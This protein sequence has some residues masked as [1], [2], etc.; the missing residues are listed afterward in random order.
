MNKDSLL[1]K[2]SDYYNIKPEKFEELGILDSLVY[3]DTP[4]FLNPKLL[5]GCEIS[6]FKDSK[7]KIIQHYQTTINLLKK[8]NCNDIYWRAVKKHFNFPEPSGIGLG[9]SMKSTDGNGLTGKTAENCLLTL[10]EIVNQD[11]DDPTMYRLLFLVQ[12][13]IGVDR[14]SD[15]IC[16]IIYE[17]L[18][19][20]SNNMI[21]KLDIKDYYIN[22]ENGLNS[23]AADKNGGHHS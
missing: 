14:I 16:R 22:P 18:C 9:T 11:I 12:E 8:T 15:M 10:K 20:F 1:I 23:T 17:D 7:Q 13:N 21:E 3:F 19:Q 5:S 6:E 4:L 2:I